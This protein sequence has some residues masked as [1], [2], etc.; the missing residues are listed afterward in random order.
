M[1]AAFAAFAIGAIA[2]PVVTTTTPQT[3]VVAEKDKDTVLIVTG[4]R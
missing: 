3:E 4:L 1:I 2:A